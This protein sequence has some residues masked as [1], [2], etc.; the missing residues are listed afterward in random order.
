[1]KKQTGSLYKIAVKSTFY[2]VVPVHDCLFIQKRGADFV[3]IDH[4]LAQYIVDYN[5]QIVSYQI[6]IMNPDAVIIASTNPAR[7]GQHHFGAQ[8][9]RETGEAYIIDEDSAPN[10]KD[11]VP[12]ITMPIRFRDELIGMLGIGAGK[13]SQLV[14]KILLSTTEL[15]VEQSYIQ[16]VMSA[17]KQIRNEFLTLI[18]RDP[19]Q[20][21]E[22][23]FRHQLRLNHMDIRQRYFVCSA[24]IKDG[25]FLEEKKGLAETEA[26]NYERTVN[27]IISNIQSMVFPHEPITVYQAGMLTLLLP[28]G[29]RVGERE[30]CGKDSDYMKKV[31]AALRRLFG[32]TYRVGIGGCAAD[33]TKI[34]ECYQSSIYAIDMAQKLDMRERVLSFDDVYL[35][36][37]MLLLPEMEQEKFCR[38]ILK[39]LLDPANELWLHTLDVFFQMDRSAASTAERLFIHRNTLLF[40][41]KKIQSMTG[42][43]PQSFGDSIKL[44]AALA[45]WKC[46]KSRPVPAA[47]QGHL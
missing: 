3:R 17:E 26:L 6:N 2:L 47:G 10:F 20:A 14:G 16:N 35:E 33:M 25:Y 46:R 43:D 12:G 9:V 13:S 31:T 19:W 15:L 22:I 27:R 29:E 1:M 5:K 28:C 37:E 34:H 8:Q 21:N 44:Y 32:D 40:R 18:L 39:S 4:D 42:L 38:D 23:Y 41:L 7:I 24:S 30:L 11:S 45:L 36:Y